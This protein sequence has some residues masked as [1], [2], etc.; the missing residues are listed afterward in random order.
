M[1]TTVEWDYKT[2][3][4]SVRNRAYLI[5]GL[6]FY[7]TDERTSTS[8]Q[9]YFEGGIKSLVAH[10]NRDKKTLTAPYILKKKSNTL[11]SK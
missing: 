6:H 5:A 9:F 10:T 3:E 8:K 11:K 1:F 7:L 2:V 4:S